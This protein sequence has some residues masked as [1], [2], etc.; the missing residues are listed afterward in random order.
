MAHT[1]VLYCILYSCCVGCVVIICSQHETR[2]SCAGSNE[3]D[4][5]AV[6][7]H[8]GTGSVSLFKPFFLQ[9]VPNNVEQHSSSAILWGS[10][11]SETCIGCMG[12]LGFQ[13]FFDV[14]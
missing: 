14:S 2:N 12:Y 11:S 6:I 10:H 13:R 1:S 8:H 9:F 7:V 4:L 3:Y 5:A